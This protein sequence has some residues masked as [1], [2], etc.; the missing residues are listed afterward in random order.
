MAFQNLSL[1]QTDGEVNT[2]S[3][4]GRKECCYSTVS[5]QEVEYKKRP[6]LVGYIDIK[7]KQAYRSKGAYALPG[8]SDLSSGFLSRCW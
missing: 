1:N 8:K 5:G 7:M 2:P 4:W 3:S 6:G